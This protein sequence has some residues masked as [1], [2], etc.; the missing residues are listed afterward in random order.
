MWIRL[1]HKEVISGRRWRSLRRSLS[2]FLG[3]FVLFFILGIIGWG[4]PNWHDPLPWPRALYAS[5]FF[6]LF[7]AILLFL[8]QAVYGWRLPHDRITTCNK[9][10]TMRSFNEKSACA[11][12]GVFEDIDGW[13]WVE[14]DLEDNRRGD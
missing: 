8:F 2:C 12:G 3:A 1:T 5:F 13:N 10:H 6:S 11:C 14:D 9:C 4:K 7:V